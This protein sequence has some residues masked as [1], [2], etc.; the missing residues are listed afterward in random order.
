[1][2]VLSIDV[3]LGVISHTRYPTRNS[4]NSPKPPGKNHL[5]QPQFFLQK[6]DIVYPNHV[7]ILH[8]VGIAPPIS[9]KMG[10]LSKDQDEKTG[11]DKENDLDFNK[12]KNRN[13]YLCV[14]YSRYFST[15][16]HRLINKPKK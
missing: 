4:I 15:Y 6:V 8:E 16:I 11:L 7:N 1:M 5:L 3:I 2:V 10:E 13:V 9:P 14:A 12:I